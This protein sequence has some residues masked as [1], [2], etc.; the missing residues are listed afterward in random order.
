[1]KRMKLNGIFFISIIVILSC[2][3]NDNPNNN[4]IPHTILNISPLKDTVGGLLI[5]TGTNFSATPSNNIV[6]MNG[7]QATVISSTQSKLNVIVPNGIIGDCQISVSISNLTIN[8]QENLRIVSPNELLI[9]GKWKYAKSVKVDSSYIIA[10][11]LL[12]ELPWP[13]MTPPNNT[14]YDLDSNYN[15]LSFSENGFANYFQGAWGIGQSGIIYKDTIPYSVNNDQIYLNYSA[16]NNQIA[17]NPQFSYPA[18]NDT[19]K[20]LSISRN[21]MIIYRNYHYK[22]YG[23]ANTID[24]RKYSIDSLVR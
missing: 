14:F 11:M 18:Y 3:K 2:N 24:H 21:K 13:F 6:K 12:I 5:I 17:I 20:I 23:H 16:G 9:I 1:M 8:A 4:Q 19:I 7:I 22:H 15:Y 10:E